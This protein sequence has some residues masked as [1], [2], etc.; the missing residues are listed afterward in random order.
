MVNNMALPRE[1]STYTQPTLGE[2]TTAS[3]NIIETLLTNGLLEPQDEID[4]T[5]VE[6]LTDNAELPNF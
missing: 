6:N 5:I 2:T 4:N 3:T 1:L